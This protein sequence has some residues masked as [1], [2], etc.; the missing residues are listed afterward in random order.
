MPFVERFVRFLRTRIKRAEVV[1]L[2]TV[3]VLD[4]DESLRAM[5][6]RDRTVE[7]LCRDREAGDFDVEDVN[8]VHVA[9]ASMVYGDVVYRGHFALEGGVAREEVDDR[10]EA[11]MRRLLE[12]LRA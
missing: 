8:A 11:V 5:P 3:L 2:V 12:G 1:M 4:G 6:L 10:F 7:R 9:I